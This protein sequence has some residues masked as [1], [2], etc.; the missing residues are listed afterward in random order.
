MKVCHTI[1]TLNRGGAETH[2]LDLITQQKLKGYSVDLI[3]IGPDNKNIISLEPEFS[4][5]GVQIKRL[6]GP[7]MFNVFS[8]FKM[9]SFIKN[10]EYEVIHS[11]QPRSDYMLY[12]IKRFN[13]GFKWIV[14]VHGKYD[15][16]LES[17]NISNIIKKRFMIT[18]ARHWEKADTVV[19][20]SSA[21]SKWIIDLNPQL[22]PVIIPYW[23]NQNNFNP[24]NSFGENISIGFLGRLNKNKGI[25]ELLAAFNHLDT[26]N[27]NLKIGGYT[28]PSYLEYL[29]S[30]SSEESNKKITYLGYVSDRKTFFDSIDLFVFPS[31]S[32]GLGLVLL[33]AMSFAKICLTRDILP[34]NGYLSK[35]SGYLF[36]ENDDLLRTLN[37]AIE[38]LRFDN[39]KI[40]SKLFNIEKVIKNSSVDKLFPLIEQEYQNE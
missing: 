39:K 30:I 29:Q 11:H 4:N 21:V 10:N 16:Y 5:L 13:G 3:V 35:D 8:Y 31:F 14:S 24:S 19:A 15:T 34:M 18:L 9:Y 36:S 12:F 1:N 32:E 7:R 26:Q 38:D 23:I 2:L 37:L 6:N 28:E 20:I 22:K 17:N 40:K 27:L 25:E 33:E